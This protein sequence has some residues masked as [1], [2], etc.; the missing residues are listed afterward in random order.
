MSHL[1]V[2][3]Q[4][5]WAQ[6][7][8]KQQILKLLFF[9]EIPTAL[10]T[11]VPCIDIL[12]LGDQHLHNHTWFDWIVINQR[13][14]HPAKKTVSDRIRLVTSLDYKILEKKNMP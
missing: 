10:A 1:P 8:T 4:A 12:N 7:G 5:P 3:G 11:H 9:N 13:N 14:L 2:Y 6:S